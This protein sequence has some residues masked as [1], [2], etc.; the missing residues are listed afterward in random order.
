MTCIVGYVDRKNGITYLGGDSLG[1][2]GYSGVINKQHKVFHCQDTKEIIM[3]YTTSFRMGQLLMY[4]T[5]LFD[6]LTIN[7]NDIDY[8]YLVTKFIPNIQNLFS[9]GGYERNSDGEKEGGVFLLGYRDR[10]FKIQSNYSILE[11][12]CNYNACGSGEYFA[13]G[14]LKAI[15]QFDLSPIE[16]IHIALKSA[17]EF[18]TSVAPPFC[19]IN[20]KNDDVVEFKD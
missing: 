3:G 2:N 9:N 13:L 7:K 20:T 15:E 11:N 10:L 17:N 16:R 6:E 1:S 18:V 5:D 14:A 8:K 4:G 12:V 19:I